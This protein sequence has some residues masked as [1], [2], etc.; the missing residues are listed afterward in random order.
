MQPLTGIVL[1][2]G[3]S[4][5]FGANKALAPWRGGTLVGAVVDLCRGVFPVT[6]VAVKRPD[7]LRFLEAEGVR[8]VAEATVEQHPLGGLHA[9]LSGCPTEWAF[10]CGCDMPFIEPALVE[11]LADERGDIE[12]VVPLWGGVAQPLC[13]L[14][15]R[16][17]LPAMAS[18]LQQRVFALKTLLARVRTRILDEQ[19]VAR[20]DP[21][22]RS[23]LDLDTPA[24]YERAKGFG[25]P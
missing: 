16:A 8:L 4:R 7:E 17:C 5:R 20:V 21:E 11:R 18:M 15:S 1:A 24:D 22:G 2:G 12:A 10:V 13:A 23:F 25:L 3:S 19:D 6:L 9:A 14:Y